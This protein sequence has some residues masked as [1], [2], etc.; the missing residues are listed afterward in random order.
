MSHPILG[1]SCRR[2]PLLLLLPVVGLLGLTACGSGTP[3]SSAASNASTPASNAAPLFKTLPDNIQ[4]AGTIQIGASVDYPPFEYYAADGKTLQGF[5]TELATLVEKQLGVTFTWHSV[6]FD[7][8]FTALKS[9]RYDMVYGAVNDTAEREQ[10]FDFV[11]YLQSAQG[12][13][14][15]KGNPQGIKTLD[16]LCGKSI[17]AVRGGV[18]AKFLDTQSGVCTSAGKKAINVLT[19]LGNAQE[20]LAVKQGQAAALL[21]GYPTAVTFAK[22]SGGGLEL[23][24]GLQVAKAFYGMVLP[25]SSTQLAGSLTKAWQAI[26]DDGSYGKVLDKWNLSD[27]AVKTASVNAVKA[28]G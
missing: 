18:Q 20:Q 24:P 10:T 6:S 15:A 16:D 8:L 9:G 21:E 2:S 26:I 12:F 11:D 28:G 19:F 22:E 4:K 3:A 17:A 23:V 25:K 27:I 7:T 14:V 5:E 13:D 1:S